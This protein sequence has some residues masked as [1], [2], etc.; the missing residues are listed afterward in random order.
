MVV[1]ISTMLFEGPLSPEDIIE[2]NKFGIS[3]L[4][5]S[6]SHIIN[7]KILNAIRNNNMN[8]FSIHASFLN[9]DI[10]DIDKNKRLK[11]INDIKRRIDVIKKLNGKIV[12][13]HPGGW[14]EDKQERETRIHNCIK[15]LVEVT[16]IAHLKEIK[17]AIENLPPDFLG[18]DLE[19]LKFILNEVR[20]ISRSNSSI[21][22]CLDTGHAFLTNS[23]FEALDFFK[24]DI[25][26]IH[27]QDNFGDN[28]N[29][30]SLVQDDIHCPP[31]HGKINWEHFFSKLNECNYDGGLIFE[32]KATSI[33]GK[34]EMFILG[35]VENFIKEKKLG[36]TI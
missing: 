33:D 35:E 3:Y 6:D 19:D 1:G 28:N 17:I 18:D 13:V 34:D 22:I 32:V 26:T 20:E 10:S 5:L 36:K 2:L 25:L 31:G 11:G 14:Y 23:L 7:S 21:G 27:L 9:S 16:K 4:E 30:R 12:V 8:V 29:D 24:N 15:S